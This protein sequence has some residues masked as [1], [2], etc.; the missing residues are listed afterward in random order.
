VD[1]WLRGLPFGV[2]SALAVQQQN[3]VHWIVDTAPFVLGVAFY[4]IGLRDQALQQANQE[5][6]QTLQHIE[7][8][9]AE[10]KRQIEEHQHTLEQLQARHEHQTHR[11]ISIALLAEA[12]QNA[13][14]VNEALTLTVQEVCNQ[15]GHP[16]TAMYLLDETG[17]YAE[18]YAIHRGALLSPYRER[19][20]ENAL[21]ERIVLSRMPFTFRRP[22]F[23]PAVFHLPISDEI[24]AQLLLPIQTGDRILAVLDIQSTELQAFSPED[25]LPYAILADLLGPTIENLRRLEQARTLLE[26]FA[27]VERSSIRQAW[28]HASREKH[29]FGYRYINGISV[30]L[31]EPL[32]IDAAALQALESGLPRSYEPGTEAS[33][34]YLDVPL[35]IHGESIGLLRISAPRRKWTDDDI[36]IVEVVA[37]RVALALE[38]ALLMRSSLRRAERERIIAEITS[39]LSGQTRIRAILQTAAQELSQALNGSEVLIQLQPIQKTFEVES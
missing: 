26:K 34:S 27:Q 32:P 5:L 8:I 20:S 24:N 11:F 19:I 15:F 17:M 13:R 2:S 25:I 9:K 39:R 6:Q 22:E 1:I 18:R 3:P 7:I 30:P 16:Y 36:D 29:L 21:L 23:G 35:R 37:E 10:L 12:L 14:S 28:A 33:T 31:Q 38:N 4:L